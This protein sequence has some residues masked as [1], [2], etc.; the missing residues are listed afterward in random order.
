[1]CVALISAEFPVRLRSRKITG[2][3]TTATS[4]TLSELKQHKVFNYTRGSM[5][6]HYRGRATNSQKPQS[7]AIE[8]QIEEPEGGEWAGIT[9]IRSRMQ[10]LIQLWA[11]NSVARGEMWKFVKL[12]LLIEEREF[13]YSADK[14]EALLCIKYKWLLK[15]I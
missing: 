10:E 13:N 15:W 9:R 4:T 7:W 1:M 8:L 14:V 12:G 3:S 2:R 11:Q 5:R 6:K